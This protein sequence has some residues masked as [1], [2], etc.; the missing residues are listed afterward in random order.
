MQVKTFKAVDMPEAL[1]MVK[2]EFGPDAMIFSSRKERRKGILGRFSKP[3]FEVTAALGGS[4]P[5]VNLEPRPEQVEREPSTLDVFQ[6][7]MLAPM[8]RELKELRAQVETLTA[9]EKGDTRQPPAQTQ[10]LRRPDREC[11]D[12]EP[13]PRVL[14]S[15]EVEELK[16]VLLRSLE[17]TG[18]SGKQ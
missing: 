5:R 17:K 9:R 8:A 18:E 15:S 1:R 14:P 6:K 16:K 7:S 10:E 3:Y 11:P 12:V 13:A 4:T 2:S